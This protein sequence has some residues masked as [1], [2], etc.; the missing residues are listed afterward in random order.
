[1]KELSDTSICGLRKS[2]L[3]KYTESYSDE[4]LANLFGI[5][6]NPNKDI[7]SEAWRKWRF[8]VSEDKLSS[9]RNIDDFDIFSDEELR[10]VANEIGINPTL[11]SD[12]NWLILSI[13]NSI[14]QKERLKK[15]L[16]GR[17]VK[18][19]EWNNEYVVLALEDLL[20]GI[21]LE[22]FR[23]KKEILDIFC[24]RSISVLKIHV[25]RST[26]QKFLS[27]FFRSCPNVIS[28]RIGG[29]MNYGS[30]EIS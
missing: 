8:S 2:L 7:I 14:C 9:I 6:Y 13:W 22:G 16:M 1:M 28:K 5:E 23:P 20:Y 12:R 19:V 10:S 4:E 27:I 15:S 17:N 11:S 18:K 25:P 21:L 30:R 29:T 3:V 24:D 26:G